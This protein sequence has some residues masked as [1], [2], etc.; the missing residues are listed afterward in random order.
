MTKRTLAENLGARA[1]GP[2]EIALK[3][4]VRAADGDQL[5]A[6]ALRK[7]QGRDR[8]VVLV[9]A[10]GDTRGPAG[11]AALDE[12][13]NGRERSQDLRCAALLAVAKRGGPAVTDA[14]VAAVQDRDHVV[15][16]YAMIG[17]AGAGDPDRV[18]AWDA[19]F[20]RVAQLARRSARSVPSELLIAA[21]FLGQS[22][23]RSRQLAAAKKLRSVWELLTSDEQAWFQEYWPEVAGGSASPPEADRLLAWAREP[24]FDAPALG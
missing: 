16:D 3:Q 8:R 17:L 5:L 22:T 2:F 18:E 23:D 6:A 13:L 12:V 20:G 14:M 19:V 24:L 7:A 4:A 21:A 1:W 15:K 9:A 10:L 11:D